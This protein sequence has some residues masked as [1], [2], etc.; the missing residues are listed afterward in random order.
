M[1]VVLLEGGWRGV[2]V[3][4]VEL[5]IARV[6]PDGEPQRGYRQLSFRLAIL[7]LI[8]PDDDVLTD[9]FRSTGE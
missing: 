5:V 4:G 8:S 3:L 1:V 9:L 6:Q 7:E 2:M